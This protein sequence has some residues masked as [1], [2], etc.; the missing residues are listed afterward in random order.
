MIALESAM[1][2]F[3]EG[4][5]WVLLTTSRSTFEWNLHAY[6]LIE[7]IFDLIDLEK[8]AHKVVVSSRSREY[9]HKIT[10]DRLRA[11]A[12]WCLWSDKVLY[13]DLIHPKALAYIWNSNPAKKILANEKDKKGYEHFFGRLEIE[14]DEEKLNQGRKKMEHLCRNKKAQIDKWLQDPQLKSWSDKILELSRK[15]K[16]AVSFFK[17]FD[18]E[19]TVLK[20]LKKLGERSLYLQYSKSSMALHGSSMEQFILIGD[21][22]VAPKLQMAK[23]ADETLFEQIISDCNRLL[24]LLGMINHRVLKNEKFRI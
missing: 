19:A 23:Q 13:S 8:S 15:N 10:V 22:V 4:L 2:A 18:P 9:S 12:A 14:T 5:N 17:L 7:P 16:G 6:V 1:P 20:R 24:V 3:E 11:Y 21:S